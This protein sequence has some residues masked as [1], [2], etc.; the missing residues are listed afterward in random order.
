MTPAF[1]LCVYCG[2]RPGVDPRFA[3]VA[4]E[5]GTWIGEHGGQLVYGGGNNG[6]MGVLADAALAAGASVIGVIPH[7]MVVRE[8]AKRDCTELHVVDT[9]HQRKSLMAE[10]ADAFL[11]LPGGIGTF[12]EFFEAWTWRHIGF[13]DKP[14]GL[15]DTGGYYQSLLKFLRDGV[16]QGFMSEG[17]MGMLTVGA[18]A[19]PLLGKLVEAA[20]RSPRRMDLSQ[21]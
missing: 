14:I 6:L 12:E 5:V 9:M 11:A 7:S 17:Q 3:Q 4:A 15:L 20:G 21:I 2:S 16:Q 13:H 18:D 10:R 19:A 1:S 8:W